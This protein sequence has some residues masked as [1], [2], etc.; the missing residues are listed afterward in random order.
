MITMKK[1]TSLA[2]SQLCAA[3]EGWEKLCY[4]FLYRPEL[5]IEHVYMY[6][7]YI[8]LLYKC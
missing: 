8:V 6:V 7:I 3:T 4:I 5:K 2:I 1:I